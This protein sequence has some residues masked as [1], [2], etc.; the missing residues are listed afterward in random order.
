M[1]QNRLEATRQA[2][3]L[4][5]FSS[6]SVKTGTN[7]ELSAASATSDRIRFGIW[8]AIVKALIAPDAPK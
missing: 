8:N 4:S 1:I 7:A 5:P 3:C 2:R 6:R